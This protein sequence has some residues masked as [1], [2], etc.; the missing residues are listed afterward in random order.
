MRQYTTPS[1]KVT[2]K[3]KDGSIATD[4]NFTYLI[5][6]IRSSCQ[7]LDIKLDKE[8]VIDGVFYVNLTQ[9][10]TAK[11]KLDVN[12]EVEVNFFHGDDR[13]ATSIQK[14]KVNRNLLDRIIENG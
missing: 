13:F 12:A 11:L 9:E 5:F 6:S 8:E 3:R 4:L 7:A 1:L 10:Q 14:L 2:L